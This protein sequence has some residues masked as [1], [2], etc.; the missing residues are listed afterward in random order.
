MIPMLRQTSGW[1]LLATLAAA[2]LAF[3]GTR[4]AAF[5]AVLSLLALAGVLWTPHALAAAGTLPLPPGAVLGAGL[6][7]AIALFW[8]FAPPLPLPPF[9]VH[10]LAQIAARWPHNVT[11]RDPLW[12][13]AGGAALALAG[14]AWL[15]LMSSAVWRERIAFTI[16]GTGIAVTLLGLLQNATHAGGI[17]WQGNSRLP[18]AFFGP[19]YHHTSAGA[20]LNSVWPV[21]LG[22]ALAWN[23]RAHAGARRASAIAAI[24]TLLV[25]AAHAAHISRFPQVVA[26]VALLGTVIWFR[27]WG[28]V[29]LPRRRLV[30][31]PVV[32]AAVLT[33]GLAARANRTGEIGYRWTLLAQAFT[34]ASTKPAKPPVPPSEWTK[35]MRGDLFIP[36][37]HRGYV[38]G[39]RGAAYATAWKAFLARPWLGWGPG[40]WTAAAAATTDDPFIRTFFQMVQFT[41]D[42]FLQTLVEWGAIGAAGWAILI[43]GGLLRAVRRLG[44]NPAHDFIGAGAVVAL[45]ALLTQSLVDFPL[46]IPALALQAVALAA[47]AWTVPPRPASLS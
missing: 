4:P 45:A 21:G 38:L 19:F 17:Y 27:P 16:F 34:S 40:G 36:S 1:M 9:T 41:H 46:Q 42:D 20:F 31:A 43:P 8:S 24:G 6:I 22:L 28:L 25:L 32:A 2:P 14:L 29:S 37:D 35:Q 18:N 10:H 33:V 3:G 23:R 39:D 30:L 12:L 5:L 13:G 15:D 11:F 26:V 47:L 44:M 7:A